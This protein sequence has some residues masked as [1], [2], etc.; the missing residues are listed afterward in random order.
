VQPRFPGAAGALDLA[1][2]I[3]RHAVW[4]AQRGWDVTLVDIS[5]AGVALARDH[6]A[7]AGVTLNAVVADLTRF[8][9]VNRYALVLVFNYLE[10]P[11]IPALAAALVPGGFL[12]CKTFT[13]E[14]RRFGK[15]PKDPRYLLEPGELRQAFAHL[16]ILHYREEATAHGTAELLARRP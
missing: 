3:G 5:D 9:L 6:A 15:A 1:G 2:G 7:A 11:L 14:A 16:D 8:V 10:R 13:T 4:L 12:L